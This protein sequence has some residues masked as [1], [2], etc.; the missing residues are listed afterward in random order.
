MFY[1]EVKRFWNIL[2]MFTCWYFIIP[3]NSC[4]RKRIGICGIVVYC[5][6]FKAYF[7]SLQLTK[8]LIIAKLQ[9]S[10]IKTAYI[11]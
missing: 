9:Y 4:K 5:V 6:S 2:Y 7:L 8:K 3:D 11:I 10:I 1:N